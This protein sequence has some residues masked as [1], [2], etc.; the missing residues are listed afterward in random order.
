M[1]LK[2]KIQKITDPEPPVWISAGFI[3]SE[4]EKVLFEEF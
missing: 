3:V 1:K 4:G 2:I